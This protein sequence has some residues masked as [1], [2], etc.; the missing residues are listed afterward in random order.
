MDDE[1]RA[2]YMEYID[3]DTV[4]SYIEKIDIAQAGDQVKF[5]RLLSA[6]AAFIVRLEDKGLCHDDLHESNLMMCVSD[7]DEIRI[8]M[9]D[10]DTLR[11]KTRGRRCDDYQT[12]GQSMFCCLT[13]RYLS[14]PEY[15]RKLDE[16]RAIVA[17]ID[18]DANL[19]QYLAGR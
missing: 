11:R 4:K 5:G 3:C 9:I 12:I 15:E 1:R 7:T 18:V 2:V 16:V 8:R 19:K 6:I 14:S 10:L 17:N 13:R